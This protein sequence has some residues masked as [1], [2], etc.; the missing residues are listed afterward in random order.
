M[1]ALIYLFIQKC[2]KVASFTFLSH[3]IFMTIN[4]FKKVWKL[5]QFAVSNQRKKLI[6]NFIFNI[7]DLFLSLFFF[8]VIKLCEILMLYRK[9]LMW[10]I[11][12]YWNIIFKYLYKLSLSMFGCLFL[13]KVRQNKLHNFH[14]G[15]KFYVCMLV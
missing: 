10:K 8:L 14:W 15:H 11:R 9:K 5:A 13:C 12:F 3:Q 6:R 4:L 7:L 2:L 1:T